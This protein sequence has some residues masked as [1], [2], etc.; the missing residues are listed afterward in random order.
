MV[1]TDDADLADRVRRFCD[2]GRTSGYE[3]AEVGHNFR[4]TSLC[5]AIGR[6]QLE[7][8]SEFNLARRGH[9]A[10]LDERLRGT[11]VET[12]VEPHGARSVYHQYTIR[13]SD[14][15]ALHRHL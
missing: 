5:A 14:R 11:S 2:H 6:A 3:H 15:D 12:P 10:Y 9:A 4:M 7:R 1:T 13:S 8:L